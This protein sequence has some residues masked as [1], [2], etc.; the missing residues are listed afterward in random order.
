MQ[1]GKKGGREGGRE[2]GRQGRREGGKVERRRNRRVI[3]QLDIFL[4][5]TC[6]LPCS[7]KYLR[8]NFFAIFL[9]CEI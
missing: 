9:D 3:I 4:I 1:G 5:P 7:R 8:D 6:I 2:G